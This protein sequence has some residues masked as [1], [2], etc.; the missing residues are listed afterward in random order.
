M[1]AR[2]DG[3]LGPVLQQVQEAIRKSGEGLHALSGEV[4]ELR[5]DRESVKF[6]LAQMSERFEKAMVKQDRLFDIV[7]SGWNQTAGPLLHRMATV[8]RRLIE[9]VGDQDA[10][11]ETLK[12]LESVDS[13]PA[14][15]R[16]LRAVFIVALGS[17]IPSMFSL[18]LWFL[19]W[20]SKQAP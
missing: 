4:A 1:R 2:D 18:F 16:H 3:G 7:E 9:V 20:V 15:K 8:E 5:S 17:L 12:E 13:A 10:L 11:R 6:A 19:N 14:H